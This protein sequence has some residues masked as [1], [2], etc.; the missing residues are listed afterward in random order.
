MFVL[1]LVFELSWEL[2]NV[3]NLLNTSITKQQKPKIWFLG[4][5]LLTSELGYKVVN[6]IQE[7]PYYMHIERPLVQYTSSRNCFL[8]NWKR[9]GECSRKYWT[10]SVQ[11][12]LETG[13][14][15]F[16]PVASRRFFRRV[17]G[18]F[19]SGN[20]YGFS[21]AFPGHNSMSFP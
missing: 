20:H 2:F 1:K 10:F 5:N 17:L 16:V 8:C 11:S 13:I 19:F 6:Q 14:E 21:E 4:H 12:F 3:E 7:W 18:D 9:I 15:Y